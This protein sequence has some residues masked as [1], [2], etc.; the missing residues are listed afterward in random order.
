MTA[1][2]QQSQ[3]AHTLNSIEAQTKVILEGSEPKY[4]RKSHALTLALL[5][6]QK[7][8]GAAVENRS[9]HTSTQTLNV[10]LL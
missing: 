3:Q 5:A 9:F 2:T 6:G 10:E 1:S 8:L 4:S 7:C